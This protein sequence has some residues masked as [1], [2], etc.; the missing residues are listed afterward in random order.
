MFRAAENF[1][2]H[3]EIEISEVFGPVEGHITNNMQYIVLCLCTV[4]R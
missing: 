3:F 2:D 4:Y 1:L